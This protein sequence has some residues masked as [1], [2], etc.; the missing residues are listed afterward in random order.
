ME[1][2]CERAGGVVSCAASD[3]T[4]VMIT[5]N[6]LDFIL[7][8]GAAVKVTVPFLHSGC[9]NTYRFQHVKA[10]FCS[11]IPV[12]AYE[13]RIAIHAQEESRAAGD[14]GRFADYPLKIGAL[15]S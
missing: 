8:L 9:Q 10:C 6:R 14:Y 12:H 11:L 7:Y 1:C 3:T 2:F 4:I 15:P 5:T 13:R